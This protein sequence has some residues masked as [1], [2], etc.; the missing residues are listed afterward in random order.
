[1]K[2]S[3]NTDFLERNAPDIQIIESETT[4]GKSVAD[5]DTSVF[6]EKL[7]KQVNSLIKII[8]NWLSLPLIMDKADSDMVR[9]HRENSFPK[10]IAEV[11]KSNKSHP[12]SIQK[13]V[14]ALGVILNLDKTRGLG[15]FN[16]EHSG[17]ISEIINQYKIFTSLRNHINNTNT[18]V[19]EI[20]YSLF[21]DK[22]IDKLTTAPHFFINGKLKEL[23]A[24]IEEIAFDILQKLE[25]KG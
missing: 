14:V 18:T 2:N 12:D 10:E 20:V 9:I 21:P 1:M 16:S 22:E 15:L 19:W 23:V 17:S 3:A 4:L 5:F 6:G 8:I 24:Q 25:K 13:V 11:L 7:G